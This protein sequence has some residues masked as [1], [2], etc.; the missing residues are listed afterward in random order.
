MT[1]TRKFLSPSE[2][3][4]EL[5]VSAKALRLYEQRGLIAP[6]RTTA[7]WRTYGPE[8]MARAAEIVAL[9]ALGLSLAQIGRVLAG[10]TEGLGQA[11]AEH[12]STLQDQMRELSTRLERLGALQDDLD[13]G[14]SPDAARLAGLVAGIGGPRIGDRRIGF[15]LPWPWD[16]ERFELRGMSA[17]TFI[18]GPL[19]S[20]KTRLAHRLAGALPDAGFLGLERLQAGRDAVRARLES[21]PALAGRIGHAS[22]WLR[23]EGAAVSDGLEAL[24]VELLA[25]GPGALIVDMVEEGLDEPA[26]LALVAYLRRRGR[27][28]RPLFLLTRSSAIL[29]LDAVGPNEAIIYCPANH[30]PPMHVAPHPG[31]AGYEAVATCLAAPDVRARSAGVVAVRMDAV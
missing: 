1:P 25:D 6:D 13:A 2:A 22:A 11:L 12:R 27:Q 8:E 7:G 15:D 5:G 3:S 23:E 14:R 31:A 26:Q 17:L 16:G 28:A 4:R 21:E 10:D 9:R 29:D 18:T 20:G 19:F 30:S 24:L